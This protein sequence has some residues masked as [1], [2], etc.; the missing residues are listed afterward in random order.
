MLDDDLLS[1]SLEDFFERNLITEVIQILKSGKE[2]TV[3]C[4]RAH[5]NL[6]GG[7][8]AAKIYKPIEHRSFKNDQMYRQRKGYHFG[9]E[10]R[11]GREMRALANKS[12]MGRSVQ[13]GSWLSYEWETLHHLFDIGADTPRPIAQSHSGAAILMQY[14]GD[15]Q[16][17][18]PQ[19]RSIRPTP[20]QAN[21]IYQR[22]CHNIHLLLS[23]NRVHGD[24]SPFNIL[25]WKN[26][27]IIIDFPQSIDPRENPRSYELLSR[28]IENVWRFCHKFSPQPDP[29]KFASR[30]W[31]DFLHARL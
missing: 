29:W 12:D 9:K 17:P 7:L 3:C 31:T 24:L 8:L 14:I 4:C 10:M 20:Q 27:P 5:A 13:L 22:I 16:T 30:L 1:S 18:A 28:D 15:E 19:L 21:H 26:E 2:A 23:H 25:Y 11:G 6:G